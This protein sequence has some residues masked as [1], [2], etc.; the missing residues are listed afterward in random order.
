MVD[1][2]APYPE[3]EGQP[4]KELPA[5]LCHY[6]SGEALVSIIKRGTITLWASNIRHMNDSQEFDFFSKMAARLSVTD[7]PSYPGNID[8]F[9]DTIV[10]VRDFIAK[11]PDP[12]DVFTLSFSTRGDDLS[13]WRSYTDSL[14]GYSLGFNRELIM[15]WAATLNI[16]MA[17]VRYTSEDEPQAATAGLFGRILEHYASARDLFAPGEKEKYSRPLALDDDA[18]AVAAK[19]YASFLKHA[20]FRDEREW[21]ATCVVDETMAVHHRPANGYIRAY[22]H[23]TP[24]P[25]ALESITC[26][27]RPY[28][29]VAARS[30][31]E[32]LDREG[33][34]HVTVFNSE[35]P[36]RA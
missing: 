21:R 34:T 36:Y 32:M 15:D 35:S 14:N 26:G 6:T 19:K 12:V 13:Q 33:M 24:P 9:G 29:E 2:A 3:N 16:S 27:P 30:L 4:S 5:T 18:V 31:R 17:P 25:A 1:T 20:S 22:I 8:E 10:A 23:L 7:Y 28:P 11:A